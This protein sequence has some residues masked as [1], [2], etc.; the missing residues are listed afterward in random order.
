[1]IPKVIHLCWFSNEKFPVEIKV[2]LDTWKRLLPDYTIRRWTYEDAVAIN[3]HFVNEALA[4]KRWAFASDVV[5][6]YALY[7]EGG[8][9]MDSDIFLHKRFDEFIPESGF[10]TFIELSHADDT[11]YSLQAAFMI[12]ERGNRFCKDML[13]YYESVHFNN[14]DDIIKSEVSPII[15]SYIAEKYGYVHKD[16]LQKLDKL[17]V[18]P[19][20]YLSPRKKY[21]HSKEYAIGVHRIYGSWR[22]RKFGRK[23]EIRIKHYYNVIKYTLLN[24]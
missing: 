18:Y 23:L 13:D 1:M 5:R 19:A 15:M 20:Y 24:N 4:K 17:I 6:F 12:G 9:Y 2:C 7:H 14:S 8:V 3:S 11:R 22:K 16:V 21:N 10:A